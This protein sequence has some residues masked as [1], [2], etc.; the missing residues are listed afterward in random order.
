MKHLHSYV[1]GTGKW[2][3]ESPIF[4]SWR[5]EEATGNIGTDT[6]SGYH[7]IAPTTVHRPSCLYVRGVAGSGKSVFSASTIDQLQASGSIVLFFFFRQ[8]VEKNHAAK[9]LVRDFA[10]QLLPYSD[11]LV[12]ELG[13]LSE[14]DS[15][16]DLGTDA[17]WSAI[18]KALTESGVN[19]QVCCVV[20]ALD[21]MDDAD[22]PDMMEKLVTLGS[23]NP[24]AVKIMFTGR[25]LPKIDHAVQNKG[26]L[27]LK[28]DPVLLSPDV[29][30]YVDARMTSLEP[31]LGDDKHELVKRVICERASGLFLHA[32]LVTDNLTQNL[33]EG[34]V[35]EET[36]PDSLD[37]LP[38]SLREVY[39]EML[40]QHASRSGVSADLQAKILTCVTHSRRTLRLIELGSLVAHMLGVDLR[41]GKDL[42]RA[43]CGRLLEMLE[44]ET[45]SVIHHS[46]TEFLH[47][48][49]R[50]ELPNAFP[51][52]GG[53]QTHDMLA[54]LCLR[55]LH[56]CPHFDMTIDETRE[57]HYDDV[58]FR[59]RER[60]QRDEIRTQL[61]LSHPLALY[62]VE[63]LGL[64]FEKSNTQSEYQGVA[65]LDAY[66][67]PKHPAFETWALMN[68]EDKLTS[69][70]NAM[71]L[72][73]ATKGVRPIPL[74]VIRHL[75]EAQA[76]LI[77]LPDPHGR[78]PLIF[79]AQFGRDDVVEFLLSR[80]ANP[81]AGCDRGMTPLHWAAYE[82][83]EHVVKKLLEAGV[84]PL[85]KTLPVY[86]EWDSCK[87][88]S[89]LYGEAKAE[90]RR[91]T[92][93]SMAMRGENLNVTLQFI[94]FMRTEEATAYFHTAKTAEILEAILA[95]GTVDIN[96][97]APESVFDIE[98]YKITKLF[99]AAR[100]HDLDMVKFLLE[101]GADPT[102]REPGEP[103]VLHAVAGV[104]YHVHQWSEEDAEKANE[105]VRLL[106]D[107]GADINATADLKFEASRS[108]HTPL[109][110]AVRRNEYL[111][112]SN[113]GKSE[114][115]VSHVLLQ[116]GADPNATT[117]NGDTPMHRVRAQDVQVVQLLLEYGADH[118]R[119]NNAGR[120]PLLSIVRGLIHEPPD[121]EKQHEQAVASLHR[122]LDL[123]ADPSVIDS[124][125]NNV[126]HYIM[127]S[128]EMMGDPC[129]I[130][131]VE[132]L[133]KAADPNQK[134]NDGNVPIFSYKEGPTSPDGKHGT[135]E[136]LLLLLIRN[137]MRLD[138]R[139]KDGNTL[140][141]YLLSCDS[142]EIAD[143]EKFIRLGADLH[144]PG[145]N[146][147]SLLHRAVELGL[148]S[149]WLEFLI[150]MSSSPHS[151]GHDG[152]TIIHDILTHMLTRM[153]TR[154]RGSD[155]VETAL[156]LV[157]SA[158]A[159]VSAKNSK[160]QSA[161]HIVCPA[162]ARVVIDSPYFRNLDINE[163]DNDGLTPLHSLIVCG[164]DIITDL[165]Q[166]G[167]NSSI[168]SNTAL[169]P[170]HCAARVGQAGVAGLLLA[171]YQSQAALLQDINSLGGGLSPLHYACLA[172]SV[173][174][175]SILL[176]SGADP[177]LTDEAGFTPLH[178]LSKFVPAELGHGHGPLVV[179]TPEI[180]R[181]LHRQGVDIDATVSHTTGE[182]DLLVKPTA[183]DLAVESKRWE[184][185][186]ELL[187]CGAR[188]QDHHRR[189]HEFSLA[190]DKTMALEATR[191]MKAELDIEKSD[192]SKDEKWKGPY[193]I[194]P[195]RGRWASSAKPAKVVPFC[196]LELETILESPMSGYGRR[197]SKMEFLDAAL[198]EHD[199][200]TII[201]YHE[202]GGGIL[203]TTGP[204]HDFLQLLAEQ[205]YE[206]LLIYF[207]NQVRQRN[208][209]VIVYGSYVGQDPQIPFPSTL[210]GTVCAKAT[211]SMHIIERLVNQIGVDI[212]VPHAE[213]SFGIGFPV[214]T[215]LHILA[216]GK[217]FWHLEAL[218][219]L[220]SKGAN[221]EARTHDG[222]TPLLV[223]LDER[224]KPGRWNV[225]AARL[226]LEHG[227]NVNARTETQPGDWDYETFVPCIPN[228][229]ALELA[230]E[231]EAIQL[232]I[233]AG[234]DTTHSAGVLMRSIRKW[235]IPEAAKVLLDTGLDP[236]EEPLNK[237]AHREEIAY[238]EKIAYRKKFPYRDEAELDRY[239]ALHEAARPATMELPP[240][241]L[242]QR[243]VAMTELLLARGADPY[244]TY[245]DGSFVLQRIVE[246]R[247]L[248]TY[249][250]SFINEVKVDLKGCCG[251]TLLIQAC[252]PEII[253]GNTITYTN[254]K[255]SRAIV[256]ADAIQM[257]LD[258][259]ADVT[260]ADDEGRTALHWICTQAVPFDAAC[261]KAF[262]A[263][264]AKDPSTLRMA[265]K[266]GRLPL[267][268]A[269]EAFLCQST[270]MDFAIRH[271]IVSGANPNI[272]DPVSGDSALHKI[273]RSLAGD[274]AEEVAEAK[275]LF[276]DL[277]NSLDINAQNNSGESVVAAAI[278]SPYP[279]T[280][281]EYSRGYAAGAE[282]AYTKA[283]HFLS[284][285][286]AK[287]DT[288]D[289]QGRNLLHIA[290]ERHINHDRSNGSYMEEEMITEL[291]T[292]LLDMGVDP[293]KEDNK[294]R[295]PVDIAVA[296][297]FHSVVEMF[298]EEG[299]RTA[300]ERK[301]E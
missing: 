293:R 159:D 227:A 169:L 193:D 71:H 282:Y 249:C 248:V 107:G 214:E 216:R 115:I 46:F 149:E 279:E 36:L 28:L 90:T 75:A 112:N 25:P 103:T 218:K 269:L 95:I 251:R 92:A 274:G 246:D 203:E 85:I 174:T 131:V 176:R 41:R 114:E 152:N 261:Q 210:L 56:S 184:V 228:T 175:V 278:G 97:Y 150:R 116:A 177:T 220:L 242:D 32:R 15:A 33:Q 151:V 201:E 284:G 136:Q 63:N 217:S 199:F 153:R 21:E 207:A 45:V 238:S 300:E 267:H 264:I 140:L 281:H 142:R 259:G 146:G 183:L 5:G 43:S 7:L 223:A 196:I 141:H 296:R 53:Y 3:H 1:P 23:G 236:N 113:Y 86:E 221:I 96:S 155:K 65:A 11:S 298:S 130:P 44:D 192:V 37:R 134:N 106:V 99:E 102:K 8:I 127:G 230:K 194:R 157:V 229:S 186:R 129:Y 257:L 68:Y 104:G 195:C 10:A 105:L 79:A 255:Q 122:L 16:S 233:S 118:D 256:M 55:Y 235:M 286:G 225:D 72:L 77:D 209:T 211:P 163:R 189:S 206:H 67:L 289:A 232:L 88:V 162:N 111:S 62:A 198:R 125:G 34:R 78:T 180:V 24:Q 91:K 222:L 291:F 66:F 14:Q 170:L 93:L 161:L 64:H 252:I 49:G 294:L 139:N 22:F 135:D 51:V 39:E 121:N 253:V 204:N 275:A 94:P 18:S 277:E 197:A 285:L 292:E 212:N 188:I 156:R 87:R 74:F 27:Q 234:V 173:A 17:L 35:T 200:D 145:S 273:A 133:L 266:Q 47:D 243:Q 272:P 117:S 299:K 290:A 239:F 226:L 283:L 287:L 40:K 178:M 42:A 38:R 123:G 82:G 280:D 191:K 265:D 13:D 190:T 137:G 9:Y 231:P 164:E 61:R 241:N 60:K 237:G 73:V 6:D 262:K 288:T 213:I 120:S 2:V 258:M 154:M 29:A 110:L 260:L 126:F 247:G 297:Q 271:L 144:M 179:R 187:A 240:K 208:R 143:M 245:P 158:G 205:S 20:D 202:Q 19:E 167:A 98:R 101:R 83:N 138:I 244:S 165:L 48:S 166:R 148:S 50:S 81:E 250:L 59:N 263:L 219:Y 132:R 80:G 26:V 124:Y 276:K 52:L 301:I 119:K 69:S 160:G 108:T 224:R 185:V 270:S 30:R 168:K 181:M 4:R 215:P 128:I 89:I 54:A 147:K 295:T 100:R 31:R 172:G 268:Y 57:T 254:K 76:H 171:Q 182:E 12:R 58:F 70:I 84:D 109:H